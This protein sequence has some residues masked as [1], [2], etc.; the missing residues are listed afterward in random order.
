MP[1]GLRPIP[2]SIRQGNFTYE[3]IIEWDVQ[4]SVNS[5]ELFAHVTVADLGESPHPLIPGGCIRMDI[6]IA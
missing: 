5:P 4:S 2:L 3:D 6:Q 1:A